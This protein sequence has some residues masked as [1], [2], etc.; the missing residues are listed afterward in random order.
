MAGRAVQRMRAS[1][2]LSFDA[3]SDP[4]TQRAL[5]QTQTAVQQLQSERARDVRIADLVV[6]T[7]IVR[8]GLGR[9]ATG[10]TLTATTADAAFAHAI[11][12]TNPRPEREIW[13]VVVGVAQPGARL[14][15]W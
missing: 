2:A 7:N 12:A 14:E 3:V 8:H 5:E 15:I 1:A 11:D 4:A 9:A 6:G 13:V 10:Y